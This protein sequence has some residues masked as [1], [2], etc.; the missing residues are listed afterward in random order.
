MTCGIYQIKNKITGEKY[1]GSSVKIEKR[2]KDHIRRL[3]KRIH[4]NKNLQA[5]YD[6]FGGKNLVFKILKRCN[7]H[8][9]VYFEQKF[10]EDL[11]PE[12][13]ILLFANNSCIKKYACYEEDN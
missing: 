9:L 13:N 8:M 12:Y 10:I 2:R 1:I 7:G 6:Q 4:E 5:A 3:K 11:S